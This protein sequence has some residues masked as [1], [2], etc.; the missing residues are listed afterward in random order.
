MTPEDLAA[1][2]PRL[3]HV[4]FAANAPAI[5]S[6]GLHPPAALVAEG[7]F[8]AVER[9]AILSRRRPRPV[10]FL[11]RRFGT[12]TINDNRPLAVG[13]LADC[14]DDGLTPE[15]WIT[16]LSARDERDLFPITGRIGVLEAVEPVGAIP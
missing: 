12:V 15:D 1:L 9:L 5:R 7:P 4:T 2:H 11:H 6:R 13:S 10:T 14:L 3:H 8:D 16:M